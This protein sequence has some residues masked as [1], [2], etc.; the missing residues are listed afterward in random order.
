[1]VLPLRSFLLIVDGISCDVEVVGGRLVPGEGD[2]PGG[3]DDSLQVGGGGGD[4]VVSRQQ[5]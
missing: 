2:E 1:M 3:G 5:V 4:R